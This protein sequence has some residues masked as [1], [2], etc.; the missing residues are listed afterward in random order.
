VHWIRERRATIVLPLDLPDDRPILVS[1]T[2]RARLEE[3]AVDADLGLEVNGHEIGRFVAPSARPA[4]V[5][6]TVPAAAGGRIF[7]A[8]YNRLTVVSYGVHRADAGDRSEPGHIGNRPGSRAWP[9]AVS[10]IRIMSES[11]Q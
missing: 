6:M 2:S 10:R 3:P 9:V 7:R 1:V 5:T 4:D 11:T 8:G